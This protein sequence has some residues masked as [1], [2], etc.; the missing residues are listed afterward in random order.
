MDGLTD[1]ECALGEWVRVGNII[2]RQRGTLWFPGENCDM[3]RDHTIYAAEPGYVRYYRDPKQPKRKFIGVALKP[4]QQLP[5]PEN[6]ATRRRLGRVEAPL[7]EI[8]RRDKLEEGELE[9]LRSGMYYYRPANW[10]LGLVQKP[11][12][13]PF[14]KKN[15]WARWQKRGRSMTPRLLSVERAPN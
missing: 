14:D 7:V 13:K 8:Q 12:S 15:T 4:D 9:T 6:A 11:I 5:T 3:G 2:Y 1:H 10:K